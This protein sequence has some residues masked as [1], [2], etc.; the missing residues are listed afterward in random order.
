V[1]QGVDLRHTIAEEFS[2]K[3]QDA[4]LYSPLN[5]AFIG[6]SVFDL[7]VKTVLIGTANRP[8]NV[9]QKKTSSVVKADSQSAMLDAIYDELSEEEKNIYRRGHN[10]KPNTRAKNANMQ[11]YL[12]ATGFE[13]LMGYLYL[14]DRTERLAQLIRLG[15]ERT[16]DTGSRNTTGRN[17][18]K[19]SKV[20]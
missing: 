13:A 16:E 3:E 1:A 19:E 7:V 17:G 6:D 14:K 5:L 18:G 4:N 2:L 9:L 12:K 10:A 20:V 8:V 11:S 15:I